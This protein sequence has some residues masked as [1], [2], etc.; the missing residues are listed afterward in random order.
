MA[1]TQILFGDDARNRVLAGVRKMADALRVTL[2]PRSRS[3]LI[4]KSW[5]PPEVCDDGE[6]IAKQINLPDPVENLGAQML[7]QAATR[8]GDAVG[9]G[10]TTSTVLAHT[11]FAEGM[12]NVVAGASAVGIRAGFELGSKAAIEAL[13][14]LARPVTTHEE[15]AHV[16][17]VSAH[18]D[19]VI[20]EMVAEAVDHAGGDGVV[21]VEESKS[22]DTTLE[23]VEGM[24]FD[25]GFISPY[26]VTDPE[27]MEAVLIDP[28]ILLHDKKISL[29]ADLLPLL[30]QLVQGGRA[31]L[32]VAEDVDGE[33]LATLVVNKLR[34]ALAVVAAKA[35][36]FGDRRRATLQDIA[37]LTGG[38]VAAE[39][40]GTKLGT[41][42]LERLGT[43]RRV[44]VTKDHTTIIGGA[45]KQEAM[46]GRCDQIR[47]EIDEST[48]DYDRKNLQ[49]RLAKLMGG[50]AVIRVG[51]PTEAEMKSRR[52]A[53][54]DA[55]NACQA[56]VAEGI[57]PGG[58]VAYIRVI[59][60]VER[61]AETAEGDRRAGLK[62]VANALTAPTRQIAL[63]SN[64]DPGV[65]V[66]RIAAGADA[67][68]FDAI[69][70]K[71]LNLDEAGIMD[72]VKV[73]RSALENAVSVAGTLLLAEVT[74]TDIPEPSNRELTVSDGVGPE[75]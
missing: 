21:S 8:T 53:Y 27:K 51:A 40:L 46:K 41:M 13:K 33:A 44:V 69:T 12:R 23:I 71:Y 56:A 29:M 67:Y 70:E 7:K 9:D 14:A 28:F 25:R 68:G 19:A 37:V 74:L 48:S 45:G 58:G 66:E 54:D 64:C 31:L 47:R 10:T 43:A 18:G 75:R 60:A 73:V 5:G 49:E 26:F 11:L 55:I 4:G 16:A 17:T 15:K 3:V 34:G 57:V 42:D 50:V 6:T 35:P 30:E 62:I 59:G 24:R 32:I 1:D 72:A 52:G 36:G 61:L 63:N 22:T 39:E 2:G 20:G 38:E 65:V